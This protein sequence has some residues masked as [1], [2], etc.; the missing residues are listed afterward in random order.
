MPAGN[1]LTDNRHVFI[2]ILYCIN[3]IRECWH[4]NVPVPLCFIAGFHPAKL[5]GNGFSIP[6]GSWD[7]S[8]NFTEV[9]SACLMGK[10]HFLFTTGSFEKYADHLSSQPYQNFRF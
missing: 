8:M 10:F 1:T 7:I 4:E 5:R 9:T 6:K 2:L 3:H